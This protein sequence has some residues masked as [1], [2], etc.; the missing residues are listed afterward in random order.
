[1]ELSLSQSFLLPRGWGVGIPPSSLHWHWRAAGRAAD[2]AE[3][4]GPCKSE[5]I[6]IWGAD[7]I[8]LEP[9]RIPALCASHSF[10]METMARGRAP[11]LL[12]SAGAEDEDGVPRPLCKLP[13]LR[14]WLG[15][16][17]MPVILTVTC[18]L[19]APT[20]SSQCRLFSP[21]FNSPPLI[22]NAPHA[23]PH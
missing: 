10:E 1:M 18:H 20:D 17:I 3:K 7:V 12:A 9:P 22:N 2:C 16:T 8:L 14:S 15:S 19:L 23:R 11:G 6:P 21:S 4:R 13:S 5:S